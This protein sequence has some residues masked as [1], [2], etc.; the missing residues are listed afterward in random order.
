MLEERVRSAVK[1]VVYCNVL[2]DPIMDDPSATY[3]VVS[4][5]F[6]LEEA[7]K[8]QDDL[9]AAV[10]RIA[11]I[12]KPNGHLIMAM[13]MEESSCKLDDGAITCLP[14]TDDQL[15]GALKEAGFV[16]EGVHTYMPDPTEPAEVEDNDFSHALFIMAK[17]L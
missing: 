3:D 11:G 4:S 14:I 9:K 6:C 7:C 17:K 15:K 10:K 5:T 13:L 16:I 2:K 12:L 8:N 1:D